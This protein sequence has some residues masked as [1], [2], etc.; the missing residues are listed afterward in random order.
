MQRGSPQDHCHHHEAPAEACADAPVPVPGLAPT[1]QSVGAIVFRALRRY[2]LPLILLLALALRLYGLNWDQGSRLHVDEEVLVRW[3]MQLVDR[4]RAGES[5]NLGVSCW[6]A[7]GIYANALAYAPAMLLNHALGSPWEYGSVC[8]YTARLVSALADAGTVAVVY[9]LASLLWSSATGA[10]ASLL[11]ATTVLCVRES[12]FGTV[13]TMAALLFWLSVWW[14]VRELPRRP[15]LAL[16]GCAALAGLAASTKLSAA[17]ALLVPLVAL[18]VLVRKRSLRLPSA[19][20]LALATVLLTAAVFV[21]VNPFSVLDR[22]SY[23]SDSDPYKLMWTVRHQAGTSFCGAGGAAHARYL[24]CFAVH[25]LPFA[26]GV[27]YECAFFLALAP[28]M[29]ISCRR[30]GAQRGLVALAAALALLGALS[31]ISGFVRYSI[32][33]MPAAALLL[34]PSAWGLIRGRARRWSQWGLALV[35]LS[36][37]AWCLLQ[38]SLYRA[39]DPRVHLAQRLGSSAMSC[40]VIASDD[41][42]LS[43]GARLSSRIPVESVST[44]QSLDRLVCLPDY[45]LASDGRRLEMRLDPGGTQGLAELYARVESGGRYRLEEV[46]QRRSPLYPAEWVYRYAHPSFYLY[47]NPRLYVYRRVP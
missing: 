37:L 46:V 6:G 38:L 23:W 7:L 19:L 3:T 12:H 21:V 28:M 14:L 29:W 45:F 9:G 39:P 1:A 13:D 25:V 30:G 33:V 20:V 18:V 40:A 27:V 43:L 5:L 31:Q 42:G 41:R 16:L 4:I 17:S 22:G 2:H 44:A 32:P 11:Y 36:N 24:V 26:M 15:V 35:L 10:I 34:A 47:D 8:A